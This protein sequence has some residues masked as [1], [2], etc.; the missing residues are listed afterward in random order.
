M[1]PGLDEEAVGAVVDEVRHAA[2]LGTHRRQGRPSPFGKGVGEGLGQG[3][4]GVDVNGV[5][6]GDRI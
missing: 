5:I 1:V 3:G 2:D 6:E 4:E